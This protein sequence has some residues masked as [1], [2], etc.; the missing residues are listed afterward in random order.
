MRPTALGDERV[1]DIASAKE[2]GA[3]EYSARILLVLRSVEG[4]KELVE[5]KIAKN[6]LGPRHD[7]KK[8]GIVLRL[9]R[10]QQTVTQVDN[11]PPAALVAAAARLPRDA[12]L[13]VAD[14]PRRLPAGRRL[15]SRVEFGPRESCAQ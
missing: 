15:G 8:P 3:I 2:S 13:L 7:P 12:R 1:E 14:E 11:P 4:E 9:D 5:L 6:Q 10:A